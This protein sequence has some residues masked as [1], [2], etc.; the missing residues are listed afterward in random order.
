M[1]DNVS[2]EVLLENYTSKRFHPQ[3]GILQGSILSPYLY[4][5]YI[6]NLPVFLRPSPLEEPDYANSTQL[7]SK[8]NCFLY[9]DDVVLI[10]NAETLHSLLSKCE[11]HSYA[12]GYCW[13]PQKC[14]VVDSNPQ[15][16]NYYLY[17]NELPHQSFFP[18]LGI[19]IK[20]TGIIDTKALIQQNIN[21]ALGTMRQMA[22]IGVNKKGF[23][24]L[25]FTRLYNQIVRPQLEYGLAI[26]TFNLR[27]IREL[28]NCQNQCLRQI[29]GG[30]S[31]T[32]TKAILHITNLPS[33]KDRIVLSFKQNSYTD[34]LAYQ[35]TLC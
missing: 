8:I 28:E 31:C 15:T 18:Y 13:N 14:V 32:S 33:I 30:R 11:E 34:L 3:T 6:N 25:I 29:F 16:K 27:N 7:A 35:T 20:Q 23:D 4:S 10:A 5:V 21:K 9:A 17:S 2:I 22:S 12:L 19:P 1:F 24:K 26:N